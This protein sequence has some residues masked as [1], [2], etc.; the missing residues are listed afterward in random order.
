ML[1]A[2]GSLEIR[3][4]HFF[5]IEFGLKLTDFLGLFFH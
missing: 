2:D 1:I 3:N 5:L 4:K